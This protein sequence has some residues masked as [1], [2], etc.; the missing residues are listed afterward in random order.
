MIPAN[1]P[2]DGFFEKIKYYIS[3]MRVRLMFNYRKLNPPITKERQAEVQVYLRDVSEP[4]FAYFVLVVLSSA[5]ATFGLLIDSAATIIGAML[6]A[7]LMS[8][9]LGIGLASIKGDTKLLRNAL[10]ALLRGALLAVILAFLLTL[11]NVHLPFISLKDLPAEVLAR[12]RP[13]PID[14]FIALAGGLAAAFA[15]VQPD[16]SAALPGVAIA[17]AL[18]PP[19][20]AVGISLAL[21]EYSAAGGSFTLFLTNAVTIAASSIIVYYVSGFKPPRREQEDALPRTLIISM[22]L[23]AVLLGSLAYQ[24][25]QYVEQAS[26]VTL[27]NE[28]INNAVDDLTDARVTDVNYQE[29]AGTLEIDLTLR[30][31]TPLV[32][33]DSVALQERIAADLQQSVRLQINQTFADYLDPQTPPTFTPTP[34]LTYTPTSTV[35]LTP[36]TTPTSTPTTTFT[37][38]HTPTETFTPTFTPSP[39]PTATTTPYPML[40]MVEGEFGIYLTAW[41]GGPELTYLRNGSIVYVLY[42]RET[43][44]G[45]VWVEVRDTSGRIGWLELSNLQTAD[46]PADI[47]P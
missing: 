8:P 2:P 3:K 28:A 23:T 27:I 15:L 25:Y 10:S 38:T 16:L 33:A 47:T 45:S 35:T 4:D 40:L 14:L 11:L 42:G 39:E 41:A 26:R 9:I 20:C 37:A 34:T 24:S 7:P 12:T 32:H 5:I 36:T 30:T 1:Q 21:G 19:L 22:V 29:F 46:E 6:V 44:N 43:I 17:T 31:F 13:T 18:M